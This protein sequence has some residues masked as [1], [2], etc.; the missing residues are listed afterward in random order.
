MTDQLKLRNE[1]KRKKPVF[2][3]QYSNVMRQFGDKWNRPRGIHSKMRR[4]MRGKKLLPAVGFRSP[5]DARGLTRAGFVVFVVTS[6]SDLQRVNPKEHAV[7]LALGLG[8]R[9]KVEIA[10]KAAEMKINLENVKDIQNFIDESKKLVDDRKKKSS[11]RKDKKDKTKEKKEK[12]AKKGEEDD[13]KEQKKEDEAEKKEN[14][15]A[16]E[17]SYKGTEAESSE[18]KKAVNTGANNK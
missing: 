10:K 5:S 13:K 16:E 12:E 15:K 6:I 8:M 1:M 4:G 18:N 9:K 7:F 3:R 17:K 2:R 11:E 14:N